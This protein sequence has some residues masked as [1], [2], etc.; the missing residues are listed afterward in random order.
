VAGQ[1]GSGNSGTVF[2]LNTN[3]TGF[4]TLYSFAA[5]PGYNAQ[6][7]YTNSDGSFPNANL[8]LSGNTLYGTTGSGGG[9]GS[10]TVFQIN[11]NGTG[12]TTLY[13]F[14]SLSTNYIYGGTNSDGALPEGSLI[15]SGN[16]LYGTAAYGGSSGNGTIFSINLALNIKPNG[17]A[18]SQL[19]G[20]MAQ[21]TYL[22]IPGSKFALDWAHGFN[23]PIIWTP[24][25]TN[26]TTPDGYV[27]FTNTPSGSNDFYRIRSVP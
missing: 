25:A 15:L 9:S 23:A 13:Y 3:G 10:G 14:T 26:T 21:L 11:T 17:L 24:L 20:G 5:S 22:G 19:S 6:G 8:L 18:A 12:F 1:G 7:S 16:T 4:T 2:S 27:S